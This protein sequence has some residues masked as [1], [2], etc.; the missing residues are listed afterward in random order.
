[1]SALRQAMV[2]VGAFIAVL[3]VA[4]ALALWEMNDALDKRVN[5]D[6][7]AGFDAVAAEV[8]AGEEVQRNYPALGLDV[9][10]FAS[11]GTRQ[12][13]GF[14]ELP[15]DQELSGTRQ[16]KWV[17]GEWLYYG[18]NVETGHLI[19]GVNLRGR[20]RFEEITRD[21]LVR[22]GL[23]SALVAL[24]FGLWAGLRNQRRISAMTGMLGR[25]VEGDLN[26]RIN[27]AR[28][29]DDMDDL[30]RRID[31]T[32]AH[33]DRLMQQTRGFSV[34]I[35]HDLKTPL[36]RL[37]LR[38]ETA[39]TAEAT[40]GDSLDQIG[41]AL[42]QTDKVIAIFDAFLR[43]AKLESGAAKTSFATVSLADIVDDIRDAYGPVIEDA[44]RDMEIDLDES[45]KII[46]DRVLLIQMVANMIENALRYTPPGSD[47]RLVAKDR[48]LGLV[49]QGPGIPPEQY[50]QVLQP[51]FRLDKSRTTEGAGLGLALVKT[52]AELHGGKLVLSPDPVTQNGLYIRCVFPQ[53]G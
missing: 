18:G 5:A 47:L 20:D 42:E 39:L 25:V 11:N 28:N 15:D 50:E 22:T 43:I 45:A 49:D 4:G 1:M 44:G 10:Q 53:G 19:V 38:L 21:T 26:A 33:L 3:A 6:L 16:H 23:I 24:A 29:R 14:F 46:G 37:R 7:K 34:N 12:P 35:A 8:S 51:L 17:H 30:A 9:V 13:N 2:L 32:T 52:I 40:T 48:E 31:E 36:T 27:P 41:A